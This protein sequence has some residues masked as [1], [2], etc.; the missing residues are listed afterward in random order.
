MD[1]VYSFIIPHKNCPELLKRCVDSIPIR[2][3]VQVIVVDDNSDADK[4]PAIDRTDVEVVLLDAEHSKGAGRARNVGL[5]LAKGTW[6]LFPDSDDYY[7]E[8]F[9]EELDKYA[10]KEVD[11]VYFS[12]EY[13]DGQTGRALPP[14]QF[15]KYFEEYDCS[16]NA[17]D[18]IKYHHNVPW[19][20]M[21]RND[22]VKQHNIL[23]E[24]TPN[25]NDIL[26]S[27]LVG[28]HT[29]NIVVEKQT[30]YVYLR[31]KNSILTR[32]VT[33]ESA[34][35]KLKHLIQQNYFFCFVNHPEWK[36]SVMSCIIHMSKTIGV[37][38]ILYVFFNWS[39]IF[40][41]R[42]D[43]ISLAKNNDDGNV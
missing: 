9:L 2:D 25:G 27:M 36:R 33:K 39:N 34:L 29:D 1:I 40:D 7:K 37:S 8:G 6:L 4:K 26:F 5:E 16:K 14:L 19:T 10:A 18:Q 31:N 13:K 3:D 23:F 28:H 21:V 32:K 38:F 42:K 17:S 15:K 30:L 12:F 41:H 43:W 20:K 35:C 11:V 24:E 22:Y